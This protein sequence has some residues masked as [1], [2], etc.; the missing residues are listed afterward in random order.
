M[1]LIKGNRKTLIAI[2]AKIYDTP[3]SAALIDQMNNQK[4]HIDYISEILRI[5]NAIQCALLPEKLSSQMDNFEPQIITWQEIYDAYKNVFPDDYFLNLLRISLDSYD[6]LVSER[7]GYGK[8]CEEKIRGEDIYNKY[9]LSLI[10]K[11]SFF[12]FIIILLL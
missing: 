9:K 12:F 3:D 8:N 1:I 7:T 2:E 4:K 6:D 11:K 10:I 5:D